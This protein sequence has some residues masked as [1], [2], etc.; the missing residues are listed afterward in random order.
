MK[1]I[2]GISVICDQYDGFLID[3][4][5]VIQD[6]AHGFPAAA[7]C[8]KT[9]MTKGKKVIIVSN[10]ARRHNGIR[11]EL[12]KVGIT[13]DLYTDIR[14]SGE[15]AWLALHGRKISN[16]SGNSG[17][18]LGPARSKS[19]CDGLDYQWVDNLEKADFVL[20]TGAPTGNPKDADHLKPT[21]LQI[22]NLDL[23]MI[24]ANPDQIAIRGGE[25][26][27]SAGAIARLYENLGGGLITFFGK[28]EAEIYQS[29]MKLLPNIKNSKVIMIGDGLATDIAGAQ[30]AD[31]DSVFITSG[32]HNGEL[33]I[34]D[35]DSIS[36]CTRY[37]D[38]SPTFVCEKFSW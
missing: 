2:S 10:A 22:R 20:N 31:I 13:D 34:S 19:L 1:L 17:Y 26:G 28:P 9:L 8:L 4:W 33:T 15:M 27:I 6:G 16:I 12:E 11:R 36:Q 30:N 35:E 29:A 18:Y 38:V 37:Y 5:G 7:E 32:I 21:L 14:S 3:S 24:C 25:I 23:P